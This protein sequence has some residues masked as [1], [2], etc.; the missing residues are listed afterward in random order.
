MSARLATD[1]IHDEIT[2]QVVDALTRMQSQT[3]QINFA[4]RGLAAAQEAVY[5]AQQRQ[6]FGVGIVL[7]NILAHQ[8]LTRTRNDYLRAVAEFNKAQYGLVKAVGALPP[9]PEIPANP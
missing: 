1:K 9:M 4:R 2:R 8:D 7:E 6:E 3:E 5:L